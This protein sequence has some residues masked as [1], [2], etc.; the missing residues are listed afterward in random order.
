KDVIFHNE[1]YSKSNSSVE[2]SPE[3]S[4][5]LHSSE[6]VFRTKQTTPS[7]KRGAS[8][9]SAVISAIRNTAAHSA[10]TQTVE[11][12]Q[13]PS[14]QPSQPVSDTP[15]QTD[16][17]PELSEL[18]DLEKDPCLAVESEDYQMSS[19]SSVGSRLNNSESLQNLSQAILGRQQVDAMLSQ[20]HSCYMPTVTLVD[21]TSA[22]RA[23]ESK[24]RK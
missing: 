1:A 24:P 11:K 21:Q 8:F 15:T 4:S 18:L 13:F 23:N 12:Q 5:S 14:S 3:K 19:D 17:S 22:V 10:C 6:S 20:E 7:P 16:S 2:V 9:V